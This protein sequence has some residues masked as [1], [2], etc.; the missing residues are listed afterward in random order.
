MGSGLGTGCVVDMGMI[1]GGEKWM[2][3]PSSPGCG[4]DD[5]M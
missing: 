2:L 1:V 4:G 5:L 3:P